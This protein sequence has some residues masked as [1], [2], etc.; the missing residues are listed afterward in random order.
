MGR[1]AGSPF[2]RLRVS[3][4]LSPLMLSL[5]NHFLFTAMKIPGPELGSGGLERNF[6]AERL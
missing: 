3:G 5:S 1:S 4:N 6:V 2:D